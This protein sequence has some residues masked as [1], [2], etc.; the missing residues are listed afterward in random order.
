[1]KKLPSIHPLQEFSGTPRACGRQYGE[2][3]AEAIEAF[4][5][6]EIPPNPKRLRYAAQCWN[7]LKTWEKHVV[8][9]VV[10]LAEGSG[11]S[12]PQ[13]TL[14]LLHEEIF[15]GKHCTAVGATGTGTA[16]G[17][18]IIG[19]NWDWHSKLYPWSSLTR[20]H[21]RGTPRVLFYSFP[22]LYACAGVNEHGL[23]LVWTGAAY[24]PRIP[25]KVGIPTYA[26]IAGL[27]AKR[28]CDEA[29]A[30]LRDTKLAGSF[31]FFIADAAGEVWVIEG[32]NGLFEAVRCVDVITRAN[33]YETDRIA[34]LARQDLEADP[35]ANTRYR[36]PRMAALARRHRGHINRALVEKLLCDRGVGIGKDICQVTCAGRQIM[37]IDS[38]Y[39]V[40]RQREFWIARGVQSRHE[41]QRHEV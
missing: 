8:D 1:M 4:L 28:N 31:I 37:T 30:L 32:F 14:V 36:G 6:L 27:L 2:A 39:C 12:I 13:I 16:D 41:Y 20:V 26:L 11:R 34:E 25:A 5:H 40:P 18:P 24:L 7:R 35:K 3:N 38:F 29:F 17:A 19:Q 9:F 21:A 22:G 33:H 15:H 10:G 23:S